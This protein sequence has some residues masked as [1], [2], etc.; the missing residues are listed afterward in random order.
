MSLNMKKSIGVHS[1]AQSNASSTQV[2][3]LKKIFS[4]ELK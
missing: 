3:N 4:P 2:R 1:P